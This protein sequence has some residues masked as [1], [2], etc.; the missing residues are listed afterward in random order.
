M[1]KKFL[2]VMLFSCTYL[3]S[4]EF[5]NEK[6]INVDSINVIDELREAMLPFIKNEKYGIGLIKY[7]ATDDYSSTGA[8]FTVYNSSKK[9]IKYI[10]FTVA[11]ENAVGDLVGSGGKY[12]KTLKGIGPTKSQEFGQWSFDY[13]WYN[14]LVEYL[15]LS[16]IK[17]QYM[18]G[19]F[20]TVKYNNNLFIGEAAYERAIMAIN[21][22]R[23][24]EAEVSSKDDYLSVSENDNTIFSKVER[25]AEFPGGYGALRKRIID[26]FDTS[27][28]NAESVKSKTELSFII[29]KDGT[30]SD[31]KANGENEEFN[32]E[33]IRSIKSIRS[34]W[35]PAQ[36]KSVKVRSSYTVKL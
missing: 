27:Q 23:K 24:V 11:G 3:I 5:K 15:K 6:A 21:N 12:Y 7:Q 8:S 4:Q 33:A 18:D 1:K 26:N 13:V 2:F 30:I 25:S 22:S 16:T 28:M 31:V 34:T 14:D 35:V 20:K 36:I 17:I 10:W 19:T 32:K 9:T 29:E